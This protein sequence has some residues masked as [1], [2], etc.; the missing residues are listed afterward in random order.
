MNTLLLIDTSALIH[1]FFHALPPLTS[2]A[3]EPIG[4]I[5]GLAGIVLKLMLEEKPEYLAAALDRPEPT[6]RKQIFHDYKIQRPPAVAE[7]VSQ[8]GKVHEVFEQFRVRV[9]E[10]PGFEA[11]DIIGTLAHHLGGQPNIRVE[12]LSGDLD[13]LQLVRDDR[14][15]AKIIKTGLTT[16]ETYNEQKVEERYDLKLRQ[17]TD[18]KALIGDS[19]DNIPGIKGVGPKTARELLKE[20]GTIEEIFENIAII[21][22]TVAKKLEGQKEHAL[23]CRKLSTI[24]TDVPLPMPSLEKLRTPPLN[25]TTLNAYFQTYGFTSLAKR[26]AV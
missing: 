2:P 10:Q 20:F 6:F 5:Y 4:A 13:V 25:A 7:L 16:T 14:I 22:P 3:G 8:F 9:F 26:L 24:R 18:Y 17:L 11:D 1:R 12:I 15:T 19:S 21:N 23:L